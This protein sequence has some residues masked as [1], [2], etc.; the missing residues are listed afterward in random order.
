MNTETY[1]TKC[2]AAEYLK[3]STRFLERAIHDGRLRAYKP[4]L[5]ILRLRRSDLDSLMEA[6][7]TSFLLPAK[8]PAHE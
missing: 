5:K 8:E 4:S 3:V 1:L 7:A 2:E 6:G